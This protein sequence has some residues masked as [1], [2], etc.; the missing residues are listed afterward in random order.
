MAPQYVAWE[1]MKRRKGRGMSILK[2]KAGSRERRITEE[3]RAA[4]GEVGVHRAA[5]LS[6]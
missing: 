3:E 6:F 1:E 2:R 5:G 4:L